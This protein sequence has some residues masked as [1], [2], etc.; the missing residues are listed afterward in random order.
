MLE[1]PLHPAIRNAAVCAARAE[2]HAAAVLYDDKADG[3]E[4]PQG[5]ADRREADAKGVGELASGW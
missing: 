3:L 4:A 2:E 1:Q 5:L